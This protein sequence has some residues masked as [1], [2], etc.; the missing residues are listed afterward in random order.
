MAGAENGQSPHGSSA[1]QGKPRSVPQAAVVV[2]SQVADLRHGFP[3]HA[4]S[5][6][7]SGCATEAWPGA[8]AEGPISQAGL[9]WA[10]PGSWITCRSARL[11]T[12]LLGHQRLSDWLANFW[13]IPKRTCREGKAHFA[14]PAGRGEIFFGQFVHTGVAAENSQSLNTAEVGARPGDPG[15]F[16]RRGGDRRK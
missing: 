9:E 1:R 15:P 16:F 2:E 3:S 6:K 11:S 14:G 5:G 13:R 12:Q 7:P 4:G 10:E 8:G